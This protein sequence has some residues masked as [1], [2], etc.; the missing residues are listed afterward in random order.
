MHIFTDFFKSHPFC[1][2]F[3]K[4]FK[5]PDS[6]FEEISRVTQTD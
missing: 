6:L 5:C 4:L 3:F 1:N 2:K